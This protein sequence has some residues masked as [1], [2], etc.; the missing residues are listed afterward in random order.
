M[1]DE[2]GCP[3]ERSGTGRSSNQFSVSCPSATTCMAIGNV[4]ETYDGESGGDQPGD[5][6]ALIYILNDG[7]W[8]LQ[9]EPPLPANYQDNLT[10]SSVSCPDV[11]DCVV[12]GSYGYYDS[13]NTSQGLILT[14]SSGTWSVQEVPLPSNANNDP[15]VAGLQVLDT[16]DC[17][18]AAD[19]VAGGAYSDTTG[20]IDPFFVALQA[21]TWIPSEAPV[22]ANAEV[23]SQGDD[24]ITGISCPAENACVADGSYWVNYLAGDESGMLFTQ[25]SSGWTVAPAPLPSSPYVAPMNARRHKASKSSLQGLSC[26]STTFVEQLDKTGND[27]SLRK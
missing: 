12:V 4:Y 26:V 16:V 9:S 18:D 22:P 25:S 6:Q 1:D 27:L 5:W 13:F 17:V 23:P 11:N 7:S 3:A 24:S 2:R 14:Y 15:Q 19:C 8:Q 10:L 21:G 20:N